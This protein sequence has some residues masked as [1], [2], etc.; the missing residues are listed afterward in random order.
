MK[1]C[2]L[3]AKSNI[4]ADDHHICPVIGCGVVI[5]NFE[6][7]RQHLIRIVQKGNFDVM[8]V[9]LSFIVNPS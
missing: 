6:N 5:K 7:M 2:L 8:S 4:N 1:E 9:V 3:F